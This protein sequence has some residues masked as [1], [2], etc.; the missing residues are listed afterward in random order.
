MSII[1]FILCTNKFHLEVR[2]LYS[3]ITMDEVEQYVQICEVVWVI[4][5]NDTR[6]K[7]NMGLWAGSF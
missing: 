3:F 1:D 7:T 6:I 4:F 5:T 2:M